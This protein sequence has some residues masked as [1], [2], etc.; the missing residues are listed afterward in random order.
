MSHSI[1]RIIN[2][3]RISRSLHHRKNLSRLENMRNVHHGVPGIVVG[4]GPSLKMEDLDLVHKCGIKS[5]GCNRIYLAFD[6]TNWRPS[7]YVHSS[8]LQ[9]PKYAHEIQKHFKKIFCANGVEK[10]FPRATTISWKNLGR[11]SSSVEFPFCCSDDLGKG[12]WGGCSV[13]Y[14]AIQLALHLGL[15]PIYLIGFD[16]VYTDTH[17]T[18]EGNIMVH[19]TE[20]SCSDH[21]IENY[22]E[23]GETINPGMLDVMTTAF[24]HA[25]DFAES[26]GIKIYNLTRGGELEVFHRLDIDIIMPSVADDSVA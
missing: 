24:Q 18:S 10:Y 17:K 6:K 1:L 12:A 20:A 19:A 7:Y 4:N 11:V 25:R 8:A 13:A 22:R 23:K 16:H 9:A 14:D 5:I 15:N 26:H 21:F 3:K 2:P